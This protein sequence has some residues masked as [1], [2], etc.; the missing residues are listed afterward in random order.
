MKGQPREG[1]SIV[2]GERP[3]WRDTG[4]SPDERAAALIPLLTLEEKIAQLA[5]V[6]VGAEAT[7]AGVAPRQSEMVRGKAWPD[8]IK[9]GLGQLTRPFGTAPV[10]PVAVRPVQR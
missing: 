2:P 1:S 4:L 8:L 3:R 10:D 5:G 9:H 7:G 6:W